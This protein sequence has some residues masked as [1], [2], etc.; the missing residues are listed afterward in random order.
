MQLLLNK[1][2]AAKLVMNLI[3]RSN[4][5]KIFGMTIDFAIGLLY[6]GNIT[7]QV[8]FFE[9]V[10]LIKNRKVSLNFLMKKKQKNFSKRFI[11]A[12]LLLKR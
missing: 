3:T 1:Q 6:G 8:I 10:F 9:F 5:D 2:G 7:V 12:L 4:D 11:V